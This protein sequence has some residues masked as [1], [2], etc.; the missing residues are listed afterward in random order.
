M[1]KGQR[2]L[3]RVWLFLIIS[4]KSPLTAKE[5]SHKQQ[6]IL[7]QSYKDLLFF[8]ELP[9]QYNLLSDLTKLY[10]IEMPVEH[11]Q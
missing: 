9:M 4:F 3:G 10:F 6:E 11:L 5:Q 8:A 1:W 7:R 2:K